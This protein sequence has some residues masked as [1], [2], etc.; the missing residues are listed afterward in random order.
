MVRLILVGENF[1][2]FPELPYTDHYLKLLFPPPGA[3]YGVADTIEHEDDDR[4]T[5]PVTRT[6]TIR[7]FDPAT[8]QMAVDFVVH[9]AE[10]IAGPWAAQATPG[11]RINFFGPGGSWRPEATAKH[12]LFAGDESALP[13]IA[14]GLAAL[15]AGAQAYT[16]VEVGGPEDEQPL[17]G[18]APIWIYRSQAGTP[19]GVA[20]ARAVRAAELPEDLTAFVHGSAE[21]I[22]DLRRY[23]FVERG[24]DRNKVSISGYWRSGQDED[25]WQATKRAFVEQMYA[26]EGTTMPQAR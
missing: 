10:G 6:Y 4:A 1:G 26:D 12:V 11:D 13:A 24:I 3:D 14:A 9:G 8:R 23:L 22:R 16:L 15:P 5:R 2:D 7:S 20:L 25:A 18:P 17:A 21:M 19:C